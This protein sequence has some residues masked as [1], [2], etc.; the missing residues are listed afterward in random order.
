MV[1]YLSYILYSLGADI[2]SMKNR[3]DF[4]FVEA[5]LFE[6][7]RLGN[8]AGLGVPHMTICDSQVG[9]WYCIILPFITDKFYFYDIVPVRIR[10]RIDPQHPLTCRKRRLNGAVL[11]MIPEKQRPHVTAGVAR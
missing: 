2:P 8:A 3:S 4:N 7:M 9:K 11:R 10:V 6:T 1:I 5:C